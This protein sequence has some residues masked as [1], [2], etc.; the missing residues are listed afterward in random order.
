MTERKAVTE[1]TAIRYSLADKRAKGV[2]LDELC[3]TTVVCHEHG[4]TVT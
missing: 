2:I 4:T 3:A 1:T